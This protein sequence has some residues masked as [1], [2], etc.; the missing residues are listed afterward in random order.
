MRKMLV[1]I[2]GLLIMLAIALPLITGATLYY[3][4]PPPEGYFTING[5]TATTTSYHEITDPN[6]NFEFIATANGEYVDVAWVL[7]ETWGDVEPTTATGQEEG[8]IILSETTPDTKWT[9]SYSLTSGVGYYKICGYVVDVENQ[10]QTLMSVSGF[11]NGNTGGFDYIS[12]G[13]IPLTGIQLSLGV[14]GAVL[15]GAGFVLKPKRRR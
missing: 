11:W 1:I 15:I 8:R 10:G 6:I 3:A 13:E 5:E 12:D 7:I 4:S 2:G 9:G 14:I